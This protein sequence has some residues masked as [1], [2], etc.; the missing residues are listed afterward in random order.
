[1]QYI[2]NT[3]EKLNKKFYQ[4][5]YASCYFIFDMMKDTIVPINVTNGSNT[6]VHI[7]FVVIYIA[8]NVHVCVFLFFL[9]VCN[10]I[11]CPHSIPEQEKRSVHFSFKSKF[12]PS[13]VRL[14]RS[15]LKT[16]VTLGFFFFFI[17]RRQLFLPGSKWCGKLS[18]Y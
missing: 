9:N 7:F 6:I 2:A 16:I 13:C 5:E 8:I 18:L 11:T 12:S 4:L 15:L 3:C 14:L 1:M 10:M 17:L